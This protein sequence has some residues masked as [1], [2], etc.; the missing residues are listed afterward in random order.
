M[1]ATLT[2]MAQSPVTHEIGPHNLGNRFRQRRM[3][4][5]LGLIEPLRRQ[6]RTVRIVDLG[7]TAAYWRALPALYGAP[8][9]E[10][11]ILNLD[12]IEERDR[13]LSVRHG[14]ARAIDYPDNA[15]DVVHSNSVIEHVGHWSE[16]TRMAQ[17]VRRL[18]PC[19]FVQTPNVWFP[20]EPHFKLPFVHWLPEQSRIAALKVARRLPWDLPAGP[21]TQAV[22]RIALLSRAQL[23]ELFPDADIWREK[24]VG[25]TKSL[26]AIR[27]GKG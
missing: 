1:N 23:A 17:E 12:G 13:N 9:V 5:F 16:M 10:I 24:V 19:Y 2:R 20:V 6:G 27:S 14:D 22:Q 7:G 4:Q 15:F 18:A 26:V 3:R 11:T 25:L 21:A 8:D